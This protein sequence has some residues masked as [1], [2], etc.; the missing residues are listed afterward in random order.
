MKGD[1]REEHPQLAKFW[2]Y[3]DLQQKES[4]R[5]MVASPEASFLT[6][7]VYGVTGGAGIA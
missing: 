6:S 4:D 7:E 2:S 3:L 1:V 5:A